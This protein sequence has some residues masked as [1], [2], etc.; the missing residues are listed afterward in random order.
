[1]KSI[2]TQIMDRIKQLFRPRKGC[3]SV[4]VENSDMP[5]EVV[6][7][8][9]TQEEV[10]DYTCKLICDKPEYI[11]FFTGLK[12]QVQYRLDIKEI[13]ETVSCHFSNRRDR[14]LWLST[15]PYYQDYLP[16]V[17]T[18]LEMAVR[19][20]R[21]A[22]CP[23]ENLGIC[24][25]L[26]EIPRYDEPVMVRFYL[27]DP[28]NQNHH[29]SPQPVTAEG[30]MDKFATRVQD[31]PPEEQ[32][33]WDERLTWIC[34]WLTTSLFERSEGKPS[35]SL[36]YQGEKDYQQHP[37]TSDTRAYI[38]YWVHRFNIDHPGT[39]AT[40]NFD[41]LSPSDS[42]IQVVFQPDE[43]YNTLRKK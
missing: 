1:M 5:K 7:E 11:D 33:F 16:W 38:T 36:L 41:S 34:G 21:D 20:V 12:F 42:R 8:E 30:F 31:I 19:E 9:P 14:G 29:K 25:T 43:F 3:H 15:V 39:R 17:M 4:I 22:F 13:M 40:F 18:G 2:F 24:A 26:L 32:Q 6:N 23:K 27:N 10:I 28:T 35:S 37:F